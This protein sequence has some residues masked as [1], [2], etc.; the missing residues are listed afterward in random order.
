MPLSPVLTVYIAQF[1]LLVGVLLSDVT[2]PLCGNFTAFPGSHLTIEQQINKHGLDPR[3]VFDSLSL[4]SFLLSVSPSFFYSV[5]CTPTADAKLCVVKVLLT[6]SSAESAVP[7]IS[8][9]S[10]PQQLTGRA[11]DVFLVHY[12]TAHT[13]QRAIIAPLLDGIFGVWIV[14]SEEFMGDASLVLV[15]ALDSSHAVLEG[16]SQ[17]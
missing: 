9:P 14:R 8:F 7:S 10:P 13:V 12:Q 4:P 15:S 16:C 2:K 17:C 6:S 11:G 1:T 5:L 3:E